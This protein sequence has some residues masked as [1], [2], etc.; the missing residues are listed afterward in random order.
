MSAVYEVRGEVERLVCEY[1]SSVTVDGD[2]VRLTDIMGK[3]YT[4]YGA[5][6][7][8]DLVA[9]VIMLEV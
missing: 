3:E 9:N 7:S 1:A 8:I 4:V 2:A 5:V 6:K